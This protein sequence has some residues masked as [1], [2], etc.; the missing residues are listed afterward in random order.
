MARQTSPITFVSVVAPVYNE[1]SNLPRLLT[2]MNAVLDKLPIRSELILVDDGSR[3]R[4]SEIMTEAAAA[5][6]SRVRAVILNRNYGQHSAII[7]GFSHVH[8]DAVITIDADLQNPPH[9]IPR[10]VEALSQGYEVVGTIRK[11]RQDPLL[12]KLGSAC[13]NYFA[14]K[15]TGVEMRD[16]GCML[17]GYRRN[18]VDAI[19]SC[20][21]HSMF[22]PILANSLSSRGTEIEVEHSSRF[23]G[24]SKYSIWKLINLQF[25]LI[26]G[27]TTFPLR[28]LNIV[29]MT[30]A[31]CGVT[32]GALL[33][34]LRLV[35]GAAWAGDGVFTLFAALFFFVGAQFM[36]MGMLGEYLGRIYNDV[37]DR[38]KFLV[39]RVVES[40]QSAMRSVE[41]VG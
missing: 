17:R 36:G 37:R 15:A 24:D 19:L 38:P 3:D 11:D 2:E 10:I 25:D 21:E 27:I 4:S 16:Y 39:D 12:R 41:N 22:I 20:R 26:T 30:F 29:G 32:M 33:I 28:L 35:M 18:V 6:G 23:A 40:S 5:P 34:L 13:V 9:E 1:E 31:F 8:G 7:A 14:R